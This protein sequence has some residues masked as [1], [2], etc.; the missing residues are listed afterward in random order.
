MPLVL[1]EGVTE[2]RPALGVA[3]DEVLVC[4]GKRL[5]V[6]QG[7][8]HGRDEVDGA[9]APRGLR[10]IVLVER[11]ALVDREL[12]GAESHVAPAQRDQLARPTAG[13]ERS[14][15]EGVIAGTRLPKVGNDGVALVFCKGVDLARHAARPPERREGIARD[16]LVDDTSIPVEGSE[17]AVDDVAGRLQGKPLLE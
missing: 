5:R 7:R 10:R 4:D 15:H 9:L 12:P 3:E 2:D 11:S 17:R 13:P 1:A 8:D 14:E 16:E 6:A